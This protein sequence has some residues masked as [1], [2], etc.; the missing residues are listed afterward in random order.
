MQYALTLEQKPV[1]EAV[2]ST[3]DRLL[4]LIALAVL[5]PMFVLVGILIKL[6]SKG[7]IFY[8]QKRV[9][10]N[11]RLFDIYKFRTMVP[12]ADK[13]ILLSNDR[14]GPTFKCKND[15][16]ITRLGHILRKYSI[17]ELPQL[18]NVIIGDMALVG[19]RPPLPKEVE[20]YKEWHLQ[21][22]AVKPGLTCIW[23]VSKNRNMSFDRWV[24]LDLFYIQRR[25]IAIDGALIL[26]TI[27]Y[28]LAGKGDN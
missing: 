20:R 17:D 16:R 27:K 12:D 22:F 15:P 28:V 10:H 25:C 1:Y 14:D 7:P 3:T 18:L 24:R 4:A 21:R 19:P 2:K 26:K 13:H 11:N 8:S 6:D 23:Q 9:G 5:S